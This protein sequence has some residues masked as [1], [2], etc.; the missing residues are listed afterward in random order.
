MARYPDKKRTVGWRA[1]DLTRQMAR[2]L[3]RR[4][5]LAWFQREIG[6]IAQYRMAE[7]RE[8]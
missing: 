7:R 8:A 6:P 2:E 3:K 5:R 4:S 1:K